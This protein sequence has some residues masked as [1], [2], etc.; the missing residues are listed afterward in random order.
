MRLLLVVALLASACASNKP[1]CKLGPPLARDGA[2]LWRA[3]KGD[4][5]LWLYGTIH[6]AGID[7]VPPVAMKAFASAAQLVTELGDVETDADAYRE[8]ARMPWGKPGI[9]QLLPTSDWYDLRDALIGVVKEDDLKRARP[10]YAMTRL[11]LHR[12]PHRGRSMDDEIAERA[13]DRKMPIDALETSVEQL[14]ALDAVVDIPALQEAIH[15]RNDMSCDAKRLRGGYDAGDTVS[16][17]A[18]LVIPKT[19]D[20]ILTARNMKWLAKLQTY[21]NAFVAVGLGHLLGG[22]TGLP[23]ML[24]K[25]GYTVERVAR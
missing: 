13:H 8:I 14:T 19:R 25:A 22:D 20:A 1:D 4:S 5:V 18:I 17:E 2:F 11:M 9:D 15:A 23:A 16:M 6:D 24:T 7:A 21:K 10:W 3:Q 12:D